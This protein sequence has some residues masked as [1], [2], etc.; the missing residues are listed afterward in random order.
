MANT[1]VSIVPVPASVANDGSEKSKVS[2][3]VQTDGSPAQAGVDVIWDISGGDGS[4]SSTTDD[5]GVATIDVT[6]KDGAATITV[7]ASTA[8]DPTGKSTLITTYVPL[9]APVVLNASEEDEWT[10]DHYDIEF[11][12]QVEIPYYNNVKVDQEV[13]FYWGD[14]WSTSFFVTEDN[15][16]PYILEIPSDFTVNGEYDVYYDVRDNAGNPPV[17]SSHLAITVDDE[18]SLTPVLVM[19]QVAEADPYINMSDVADGVSVLVN[20]TSM[21][22]GDAIWLYWVAYDSQGRKIEAACDSQQ[23]EVIADQKSVT[24]TIEQIKFYPNGMGYEGY[25]EAYYTVLPA[26]ATAKQLSDTCRCLVDTV[27]A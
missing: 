27:P 5:T 19:P 20:Y 16:P 13:T 22:E 18:G 23:Y 8:D 3:T 6:A 15:L 21:A 7:T 25:A 12:V 17:S 2:A 14:A 11:G 10:L 1:I 4:A 9:K 26:G 24:F